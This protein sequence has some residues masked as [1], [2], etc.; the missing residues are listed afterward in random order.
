M[1][2]HKKVVACI[3]AFNAGRTVGKVITSAREYVDEVIVVNDG[4]T[5]N[6]KEVSITSGARVID[7]VVNLGYGGAISTCLK[8]A[9][10]AE[11]D[12]IITL[13]ADLQHDPKEIPLLLD[14]ILKARADIVTGSRFVKTIQGA[15]LPTHRRVGITLLTKV[16]NLMAQTS[17]SD[18][19]TG[20]R[21]YSRQSV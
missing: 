7:H 9:V 11:A 12:I 17:I 4:S 3:P 16:T 1:S 8:T 13:D 18:A 20:F 6:T 19:T 15:A 2:S 14:P 21:A 5:D 10:K